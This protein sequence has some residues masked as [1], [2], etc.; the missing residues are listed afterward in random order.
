MNALAHR[1]E[2]ED[3]IGPLTVPA[4]DK[5]FIIRAHRTDDWAL[6]WR[7]L[8]GNVSSWN[9]LPLLVS[10]LC[11]VVLRDLKFL[12]CVNT[13]GRDPS[14][15]CATEDVQTISI[16]AAAATR[17]CHAQRW[18]I[19]PPIGSKIVPQT[20]IKS[21]LA[22]LSTDQESIVV[23]NFAQTRNVPHFAG[24]TFEFKLMAGILTFCQRYLQR[25]EQFSTILDL[26]DHII[27]HLAGVPVGKIDITCL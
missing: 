11:R 6:P 19:F 25:S 9:E 8:V 12:N 13:A 21:A 4:H 1:V 16:L 20:R 17:S 14:R 24:V 23:T 3:F 7:E 26:K 2:D 18:H 22:V 5:Y 15:R 10:L 27:A